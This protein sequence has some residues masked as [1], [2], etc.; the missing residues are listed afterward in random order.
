[1]TI[2]VA[3]T[4]C[5]NVLAA[6]FARIEVPAA[7]GEPAL[8][9]MVWSPCTDQP[10]SNEIGPYLVQG[11]RNCKVTGDKLPL[12]VVSHGKGASLLSHHDTATALANAGFVVATLSHPGDSFGDELAGQQLKIFESRPRDISRLISYM[13]ELW[14]YRQQLNANAIG[15]FGFSRGGYTALALAGAVPSFSASA[16]RLCS[17][18]WSFVDSLCRQIKANGAQL[19]PKADSRI[20]AAVVVDPLN[21]FDAH[22]LQ[23][24]RIPVQLWASEQGGD[25]VTLAHI[26][27]IKAALPQVPD[28]HVAQGAGHFA[29]LAPCSQKMAQAAAPS[30]CSDPKGFDRS[31]W[32]LKMNSAVVSFFKQKLP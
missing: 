12:V 3:A 20:R 5:C 24:V 7:D 22:G 19:N 11:V 2:F 15:V 28:Y 27:A 30:I 29:Y 8:N 1:M 9:V 17:H 14:P 31:N 4:F 26:E 23:S 32:H 25:G 13:T 21:L 10:S 16:E 18:W 6:G